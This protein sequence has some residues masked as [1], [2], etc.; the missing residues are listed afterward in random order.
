[1]LNKRVSGLEPQVDAGKVHAD[2]VYLQQPLSCEVVGLPALRVNDAQK[3]VLFP[4][5]HHKLKC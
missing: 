5:N 2:L 4:F 1:M 3:L